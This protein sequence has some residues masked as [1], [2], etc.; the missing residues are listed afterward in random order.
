MAK[1]NQQRAEVA[2]VAETQRLLRAKEREQMSAEDRQ[3]AEVEEAE[4]VDRDRERA[5]RQEERILCNAM[6]VSNGA[7]TRSVTRRIVT[8]YQQLY[9]RRETMDHP[10]PLDTRRLER[11]EIA[12]KG[13]KLSRL[14]N[15][16][17][18]ERVLGTE[19]SI[20]SWRDQATKQS[21]NDQ[22][23]MERQAKL[24]EAS[25]MDFIYQVVEEEKNLITD[26]PS[27]TIELAWVMEYCAG[28]EER[29][30]KNAKR[31]KR[32]AV[33]SSLLTPVNIKY[34]KAHDYDCPVCAEQY[35][36]SHEDHE[37]EN[38]AH[39]PCGHIIGAGCLTTWLRKKNSCPICRR[40]CL[41]NFE[42]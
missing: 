11:L 19:G 42:D 12:L 26:N 24:W 15:D 36:V 30:V 29:K 35:G 7:L 22:V 9:H 13:V 16:I 21:H 23:E 1:E 10:S 20:R 6:E 17:Y 3:V 33:I 5:T 32:L 41:E 37:A 14:V 8:R 28:F 27:A 34:L 38:P 2:E 39:L 18:R 31:A 4:L 25:L 40:K